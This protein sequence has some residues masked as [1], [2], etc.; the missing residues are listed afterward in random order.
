MAM[1]VWGAEGGI[2]IVVF[3]P[4]NHSGPTGAGREVPCAGARALVLVECTMQAPQR[5]LGSGKPGFESQLHRSQMMP[6]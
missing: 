1:E 6:L 3:F 2:Q 4:D 5:P